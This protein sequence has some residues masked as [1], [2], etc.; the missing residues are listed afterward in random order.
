MVACWHFECHVRGTPRPP[1][2]YSSAATV[3]HAAPIHIAKKTPIVVPAIVS[4][5]KPRTYASAAVS[6]PRTRVDNRL[7]VQFSTDHPSLKMSPYAVMLHLN[8]FLKE[9]LVLEIQTTKT[10][11]AIFPTLT[12]AQ[13]VEKPTNHKAYLLS[14]VTRSYAGYN[15]TELELVEIMATVVAEALTDLTK[16]APISVLKPRNASKAEYAAHK[17]W[18]VLFPEESSSLSR[19]LP[20]FGIRV[21]SK[22]LPKK[23]KLPQ[24]RFVVRPNTLRVNILNVIQLGY[25]N[26]HQKCLIRP[27]KDQSLPSKSQIIEIRK[28]AAA[29]ARL[30]LRTA[31]CAN[32]GAKNPAATEITPSVVPSTPR[33]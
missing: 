7:L 13:E 5:Q 32:L 31:H 10:G 30:R 17:D 23:T 14:G 29:V 15:G 12:A 26:A 2:P 24:C 33:R 18:V 19:S 21:Q 3:P 28:S 20:L 22:L 25:I 9:K 27:R 16:V 1:P 8:S 11:F 4:P 6:A